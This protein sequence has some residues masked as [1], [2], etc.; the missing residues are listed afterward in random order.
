MHPQRWLQYVC[1]QKLFEM[2]KQ[3]SDVAGLLT[4]QRPYL[5]DGGFETGLFFSRD[6]KRWNL[7]QLF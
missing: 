7:R 6:L 2:V 5:T 4:T 1:F 3:M